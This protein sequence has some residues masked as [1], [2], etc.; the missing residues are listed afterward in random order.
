M[1]TETAT[2]VRPA[3]NLRGS[4]S[5]PGDKS[6]SHR[7]AMLAGI[8]EGPSRLENYSTGADCASTLGCM[9]SLGVNWQRNA[10]VIEVQ[11][12]GLRLSTPSTPLDCGNSGSTMRMLSGIVA[13]QPFTI[14]DMSGRVV[15]RDRGVIRTTCLFD[16][17]GDDTPGGVFLDELGVAVP[18][19]IPW[20]P[21]TTPRSAR[22]SSP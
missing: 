17:L 9:R 13:G 7:Y 19:R 15:S 6:I 22:S 16:T 2:T 20:F 1:K 10:N 21:S 18:D 3:R 8:A 11:G 5:L 4:V 12:K 14:R